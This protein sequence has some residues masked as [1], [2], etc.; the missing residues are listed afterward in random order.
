VAGMLI[1]FAW[2]TQSDDT[3]HSYYYTLLNKKETRF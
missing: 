3:F 1:E 2:I